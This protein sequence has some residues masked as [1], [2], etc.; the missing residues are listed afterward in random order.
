MKK[1][2]LVPTDFSEVC[3]NA[4]EHGIEIAK[5]FNYDLCILHVIDKNTKVYLKKIE[6]DCNSCYRNINFDR[7]FNKQ[8]A[9]YG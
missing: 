3:D 1:N 9:L 4:L 5:F 8:H 7:I 6:L 2:I